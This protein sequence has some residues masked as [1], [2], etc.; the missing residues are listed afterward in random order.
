MINVNIINTKSEDNRSYHVS[1]KKI[2]EILGFKTQ[3]T[4]RDSV[5]DLKKAFEDNLL[6][7]SFNDEIYFNIKRMQSINLK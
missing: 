2:N 7:N 6:P 1:S 4:V 5:Q 3:F